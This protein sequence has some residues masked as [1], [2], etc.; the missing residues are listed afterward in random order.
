MAGDAGHSEAGALE[1]IIQQKSSTLRSR[2]YA[3]REHPTQNCK[4]QKVSQLAP[5]HFSITDSIQPYGSGQMYA[6]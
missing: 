1:V 4:V 5:I 6:H 3:E 2:R